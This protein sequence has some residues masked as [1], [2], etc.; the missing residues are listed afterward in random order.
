MN[1]DKIEQRQV[2]NVT[3]ALAGAVAGVQVQSSN[4]QPGTS[5][6]IRVRGV[7]SINAGQDPLYVVDGVPLMVTY[8]LSIH[9]ILNHSPY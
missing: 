4:G 8:L 6:T 9:L 2:S 3:N 5:A 7:G 1:A